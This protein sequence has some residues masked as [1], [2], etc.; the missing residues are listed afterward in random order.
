MSIPPPIFSQGELYWCEPDPQDTVG[1][2]LEKDRPW[3]LISIPQLSRGNCVVGVPLSTRVEKACAHLIKV[4]ASEITKQD[5]TA[6]VDCV[7]LTDQIRCLDK[8]RLRKKAGFVSI[9]AVNGILMGLDFLFGKTT[10][11]R[12]LPAAKPAAHD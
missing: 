8:R 4:P 5:G 10:L 3:V 7:A 2:E 1:S 6:S 9:R 11:P 12:L